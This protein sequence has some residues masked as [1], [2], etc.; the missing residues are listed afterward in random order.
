MQVFLS[1]PKLVELVNMCTD[2][3]TVP[4]YSYL[5]DCRHGPI[6][7]MLVSPVLLFRLPLFI[8]LRSGYHT[9]QSFVSWLFPCQFW[10]LFLCQFSQCSWC[11]FS[12]YQVEV[13]QFM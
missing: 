11:A 4:R 9:N 8:R 7:Y 2:V 3:C 5:R 10:L 12:A 1:R 13:D 6:H